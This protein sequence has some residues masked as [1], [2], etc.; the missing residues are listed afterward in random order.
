MTARL[1][2]AERTHL[3]IVSQLVLITQDA[4]PG[5]RKVFKLENAR[6]VLGQLLPCVPGRVAK[7]LQAPVFRETDAGGL[8][9][10]RVQLV[11]K[12]AILFR[13]CLG[14]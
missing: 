5:A 3:R 6:V 13:L 10:G 8:V 1:C 11:G 4:M 12:L 14:G 9:K 2:N 7:A